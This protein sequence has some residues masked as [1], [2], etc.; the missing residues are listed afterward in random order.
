MERGY[1]W[2]ESTIGGYGPKWFMNKSRSAIGGELLVR[3]DLWGNAWIEGYRC[4]SCRTLGL[5]Y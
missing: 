2:A 5:R 1:V 3:Q 4:T